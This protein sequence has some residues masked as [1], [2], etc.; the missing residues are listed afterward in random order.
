MD[1][2][3]TRVCGAVHSAGNL[4]FSP[5]DDK[6]FSAIGNRV[7][8]VDLKRSAS[9]AV[10]DFEARSDVDRL[11][12]SGDGVL[13]VVADVEGR[14][15]ALNVERRAVLHR[16]HL[17]KRVLDMAFSHDDGV[18]AATH[19]RHVQLWRA[20]ARR[21]RELA[22]FAKAQTFGGFTRDA[23]CVRWSG[24][25]KLLAVGSADSSVRVF[26]VQLYDD[27]VGRAAESDSDDENDEKKLLKVVPYV[28]AAHKDAVVACFWGATSPGADATLL[29]CARD[30]VVAFWDL[31]A[32]V[33]GAGNRTAKLGVK[34]FLWE[35]ANDGETR[36][37]NGTLVC[38]AHSAAHAL[39]ACAFSSGVFAVYE[40]SGDKRCACVHRLSVARGAVDAIALDR[41]GER[42]AMGSRRFGQLVVWEWRSE[43]FALKQQGHDH[44]ATCV[45]WSPDGRVV[46]TGSAD[47]RVKLWAD[48]TGFCFATFADHAAPVTAV[49]VARNVVFS[50]SLDGTVRAYDLKRYRNFRTFRTPPPR[51]SESA[52][53]S[54]AVLGALRVPVQG[55]ALVSLAVDADAEV[56]CAGSE[57]PFEIYVWSVRTGKITDALAAHEAPVCTLAL[58]PRGGGSLASGSWDK[59]VRL[60][61]VYRNEHVEKLDHP[62]EVLAI[63]YRRD[64]GRLV[65]ACMDGALHVWEPNDARLLCV[66]DAARDLERSDRFL[67]PGGPKRARAAAPHFSAVAFSADGS[68]VIAGG[69][70]RFVCVYAVAQKVLVTKFRVSHHRGA[71]A[72]GDDVDADDD[73]GGD[74]RGGDLDEI[75]AWRDAH[76]GQTRATG[77]DDDDDDEALPGAKRSRAAGA[78]LARA[79]ARVTAVAFSPTGRSFAA[80]TPGALLVFAQDA[81]HTFAP[82]DVDEDATTDAAHDALERGD[83]ARAL[84]VALQLGDA[85]TLATVVAGIDLRAV[86]VVC[87]GVPPKRAPDLLRHL[88]A[89]VDAG[90]DFE[91]YAHWIRSLLRVHLDALRDEQ[92]VLKAAHRA[93]TLH[94]RALLQLVDDNDH[95]LDFLATEKAPIPL[96]ES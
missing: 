18:L 86:D 34:K 5:R 43:A 85:K 31:T 30:G 7:A 33:R 10:G 54:R 74:E 6:L 23:T 3:L 61:K 35:D 53:A 16:V 2:G 56:V 78:V 94:H 22:P 45:A 50:A 87:A 93:L 11:A 49:A 37:V 57:D 1:Y 65:C 26:L 41:S 70:S 96:A 52:A 67:S 21:R 84:A 89:R 59:T 82:Y 14:V 47:R 40:L 24:D 13:L 44:E 91:H 46:A 79:A 95:A 55:A 38:A 80:C 32:V 25:S 68:C 64:G 9:N 28:L 62:A 17:K 66:I 71:T 36:K 4:V 73:G 39:L 69:N 20:P 92:P 42:I 72:L 81:D 90:A 48:A 83:A 60:W 51:S 29:S 88:A 77:S 76:A 15:T 63:A 27:S 19:G 8:Y 75:K 12:L 58:D